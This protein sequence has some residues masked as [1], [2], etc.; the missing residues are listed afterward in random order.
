MLKMDKTC[1]LT[2]L[3]SCPLKKMCLNCT[4][5]TKGA[6]GYACKNEKVL[7]AGKAKVL[8]SIP[9]GWEINTESLVMQPKKLNKP[10]SVCGEYAPNME[11]INDTI[12]NFFTCPEPKL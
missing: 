11:E 10:T 1:I 6:D 8:A 3:E 4:S 2:G 5:L 7:A 12:A 9:E